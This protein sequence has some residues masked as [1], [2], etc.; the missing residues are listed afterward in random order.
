[1]SIN[2]TYCC[3]GSQTESTRGVGLGPLRCV[4]RA[5]VKQVTQYPIFGLRGDF[6]HPHFLSVTSTYRQ[7]LFWVAGFWSAFHLVT[8]KLMPDPITP[9]L[10]YAAI[11][12]KDDF[13]TDI[14]YIR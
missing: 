2:L 4:I 14:D 6:Y 9:W 3:S 5:G 11:Y 8:L 10:F 1:M 13:P 12:G 7:N